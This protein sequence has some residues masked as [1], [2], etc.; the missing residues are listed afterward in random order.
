MNRL[1][2]AYALG[3][4]LSIGCSK[5]KEP[6]EAVPILP[7][8]A[9]ENTTPASI[10]DHLDSRFAVPLLP[11]MANHQKQSMRDHLV[12]V[13]EIVSALAES[14]FAAMERA[15]SRIGFS[16][17]MGMMCEHMGKGAA[18]FSAQAVEF[19]K[20]ADRIAVAARGQ[21]ATAV[22]RELATTLQTCTACHAT[23]KQQV[24]SED[25]WN[26]LTQPDS[27]FELGPSRSHGPM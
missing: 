11:A 1:L 22:L 19:H 2:C 17:Q 15:A 9:R 20:R 26:R 12:A 24:V 7:S 8:T 13:Q 5:S 21:D 3:W 16:E 27:P 23:W 14:D 25:E 4:L 6:S 10:L 18:G